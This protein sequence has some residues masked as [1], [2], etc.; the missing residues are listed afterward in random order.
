MQPPTA[1]GRC[2]DQIAGGDTGWSRWRAQP[3]GRKGRTLGLGVVETEIWEKAGG[4]G[5]GLFRSPALSS[6]DPAVLAGSGQVHSGSPTDCHL[7]SARFHRT[8]AIF[9]N[10]DAAAPSLPMERRQRRVPRILL[11]PLDHVRSETLGKTTR[12]LPSWYKPRMSALTSVEA[13]ERKHYPMDMR[14][15]IATQPHLL[16]DLQRWLTR[17]WPQ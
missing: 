12:A 13:W 7:E 4:L 3:A 2:I 1:M 6:V 17:R 16:S 5:C 10:S 9:P 8:S 14:W 15:K 11:F